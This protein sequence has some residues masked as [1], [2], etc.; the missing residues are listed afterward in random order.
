L[1]T[2]CRTASERIED[3]CFFLGLAPD[4]GM[5]PLTAEMWRA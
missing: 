2:I 5:T 1:V 3:Y 4:R